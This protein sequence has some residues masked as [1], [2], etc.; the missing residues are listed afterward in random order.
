MNKY[1]SQNKTPGDFIAASDRIYEQSLRKVDFQIK[2]RRI[3]LKLGQPLNRSMAEQRMEDIEET[4]N[5][6]TNDKN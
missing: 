4:I 1:L 2:Q 3:K 6:Q 5:Q